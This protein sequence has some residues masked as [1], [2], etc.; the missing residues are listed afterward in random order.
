MNPWVAAR[1][2]SWMG[3][4][5]SLVTLVAVATGCA[6]GPV[7]PP[8]PKDEEPQPGDNDEPA[9]RTTRPGA[10]GSAGP[11]V[12]ATGG[13]TGTGGTSASA[14]GTSAGGAGGTTAGTGGATGQAGGTATAGQGGSASEDAGG[15]PARPDARAPADTAPLAAEACKYALCESFETLEDGAYPNGRA[16]RAGSAT[17]MLVDSTRAARGKKSMK[18][19]TAPRPSELYLRETA[20]LE[21]TG[22]AFY[23]RVYLYMAKQPT[24]FVHWN[25]I[26]ARGMDGKRAIRHGGIGNGGNSTWLFNVETHGAGE[27]AQGGPAVPAQRWL[28]VEWFFDG[29]KSEAVLWVDGAER[30]RHRNGFG[31]AYGFL[32][33]WRSVHVGMALY[34]TVN[35]GFEAYIDELVIDKARIGCEMP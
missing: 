15:S 21:K 24:A 31:A 29:D 5:A 23:G 10:G 1:A 6:T 20:S 22:N 3:R 28:C 18:I 27:R 26:E 2:A 35:A 30:L 34:Q 11:G 9:P 16:W 13:A 19:V 12:T 8:R 25:L 32:P 33:P 7:E 14:A 17:S 4:P